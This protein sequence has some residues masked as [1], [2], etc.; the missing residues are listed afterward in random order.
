MG[1]LVTAV[2]LVTTCGSPAIR[3]SPEPVTTAVGGTAPTERT[4]KTTSVA[5]PSTQP[6]T[7]PEHIKFERISLEQGLSQSSVFCILQDN[8]GFM[9]FG[10]EDGLDRYDGHNFAVY[11]PVPGDP[12]SLTQN[13]V[14]ALYEDLS[15]DLWI[16]TGTGGLDRLDRDRGQFI[17]Y[18]YDPQDPHSLSHNSVQVIYQDREGVLWIGTAGGGLNRFDREKERFIRYQAA[19]YGFYSLSNDAVWAIYEDREGVL[20]IG[21]DRGL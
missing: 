3:I 18:Q 15:G 5:V 1:L 21:T 16:G 17:H 2:L 13:S 7:D 9:W 10:T 8:R 12:N 14:R 6:A 20:W 11:K 19:P 4:P